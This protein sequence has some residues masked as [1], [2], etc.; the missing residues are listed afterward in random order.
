MKPVADLDL[1]FRDAVNYR[2]NENKELFNKIFL[3]TPELDQLCKTNI[4]F[5]IG[6]KGT[7]K[8]AY[9]VFMSNMEYK[10]NVA[11][12]KY[13]HETEYE[14]FVSMKKSKNLDLLRA[15]STS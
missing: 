1:G 3:R 8:T 9:A 10:N 14:K 4:N 15:D 12:V 7:G 13:I 11:S 5:L 2:S 6:E